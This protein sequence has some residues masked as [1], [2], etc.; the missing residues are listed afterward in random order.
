MGD[1]PRYSDHIWY[2]PKG[3][4]T[5]P[6]LF[7]VQNNHLVTYSSQ[8]E[9]E[10]LFHIPQRPTFKMTKAGMLYNDMRNLL[11]NK[12][13]HIM[14]ND[15]RYSIPQVKDKRKGYTNRNIKS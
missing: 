14:A 1:L 6:S 8:D 2:K 13:A 4:D 3:I 11:R 15:S 10:F 12:Y 9:N 5:P 7:I